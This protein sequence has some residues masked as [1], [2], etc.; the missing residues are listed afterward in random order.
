MSKLLGF[1]GSIVASYIG[2]YLAAPFGFMTAF[3]VSTVAAGFGLYYG[4]KYGKRYE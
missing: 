4:I 1:V 3:I 2:W